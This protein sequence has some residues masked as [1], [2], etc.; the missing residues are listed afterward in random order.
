M[1]RIVRGGV[2]VRPLVG[3]NNAVAVLVEAPAARSDG[4]WRAD[5]LVDHKRAKRAE[6][7]PD[8]VDGDR[9]D[10]MRCHRGGDVK[11][12]ILVLAAAGVA[13]NCH[14]PAGGGLGA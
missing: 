3:R 2:A 1:R 7:V 8:G 9:R 12:L 11:A 10:P 14:W 6:T 5:G 4:H 13:E